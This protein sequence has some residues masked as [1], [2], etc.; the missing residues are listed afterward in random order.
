M[1]KTMCKQKNGDQIVNHYIFQCDSCAAYIDESWPHYYI[2]PKKH[3]CIDC[4]FILKHIDE[5]K[6][7][8]FNGIVNNNFHVAVNTQGKVIIWQGGTTAPWEIKESMQRNTLEYAAW[9]T[10]VF[11]RDN[12]TCQSCGK[13]GG[14]LNA[15]HI[16]SFKNYPKLRTKIENGI[17]LCVDCHKAQHRKS[18]SKGLK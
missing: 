13:L 12:Y 4:A 7:L 14:E 5:R 8:S 3:Y 1:I 18:I 15:H 10:K 6:Y 11:I 2:H 9:R 17:T 16:K